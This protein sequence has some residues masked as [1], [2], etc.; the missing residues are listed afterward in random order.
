MRAAEERDIP[1]I[2]LNEHSLIQFGHGRYQQRIQATITSRTPHIAVEL[3]SDKEET[4]KILANLGLPVPQQ[5]LVQ[6]EEDAVDGGASGSATRWWSSRTTPT[7]AAASRSTSPTRAQVRAAF[8]GGAGA[9]PQRDRREL[10]HRATTTGCWWSTA[11]WSRWPSGC[12]GHVVG[13]GVHTIE[14]LVDDVNSDPRR[15]IGH[16]KVL[17]RLEF[18][19]QAER[20][21]AKQGYTRETVPAGGRGGLPALHRQPLTGGTAIDVT[22]IVHPDNVEMAVRAVKAIGLDVGGVDFLTPD[23][24]ESLQGDRRRHLRG[25]RRA[26]LPHAHGAERG[27]AARRRR[28]GDRHA[29][30]AGHAVAGSRSRRSPAPTARPPR[31]A[32]WPT[33]TSWPGSTSGSPPPTAST[34]TASAP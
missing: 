12:P 4:N 1:W 5:R 17:T 28:A 10:H 14:E 9:Q 3:A 18:D 29:V 26:R 32:C 27:P 31:R 13:D 21:L 2:R 33:S 30:P 34:S 23:I 6:R 8:R 24:T 16:E 11:S 7:T 19:H 25:E 22:D 20:L 15:G